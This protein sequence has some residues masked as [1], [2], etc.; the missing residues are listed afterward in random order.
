MASDPTLL[1]EM[2]DYWTAFDALSTEAERA[3]LQRAFLLAHGGELITEGMF[4]AIK[5][6]LYPVR[7]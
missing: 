2:A 1:T 6:G 7:A 4:T 3:E 5:G